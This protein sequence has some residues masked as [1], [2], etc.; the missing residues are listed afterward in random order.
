MTDETIALSSLRDATEDD[1][2]KALDG[3]YVELPITTPA[4]A[5]E[6]FNRMVDV[7]TGEGE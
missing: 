1:V 3:A 5:L 2:V 7:L 4:A 6:F